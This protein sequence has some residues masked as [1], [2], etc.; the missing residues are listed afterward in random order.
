MISFLAF[1]ISVVGIMGYRHGEIVPMLQR[2]QY[3]GYRTKWSEMLGDNS[4]RFGMEHTVALN[5]VGQVVKSSELDDQFK[6]SFSF[7]HDKHLIPWL[8]VTDGQGQF[9][10]FVH[11][12]FVHSG[13]YLTNIKWQTE[14]HEE[15][16]GQRPEHVYIRYRWEGYVE[17]DS[18]LG[19]NV[20]AVIGVTMCWSGMLIVMFGDSYRLVA[21]GEAAPKAS[22]SAMD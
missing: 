13:N 12:T 18:T 1:V 11:I 5:P 4:P 10:N 20:L 19:F 14:Y 2:V 17:T 7:D 16:R 22:K 8:T 6:I 15:A 9:L 3:K 21:P